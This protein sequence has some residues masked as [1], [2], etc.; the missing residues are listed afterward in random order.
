[1]GLAQLTVAKEVDCGQA[2]KVSRRIRF[3]ESFPVKMK[4]DDLQQAFLHPRVF[5]L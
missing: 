2:R 4:I 3:E 5:T 1:M